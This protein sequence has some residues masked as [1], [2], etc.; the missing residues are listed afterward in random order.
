M[1]L[2]FIFSIGNKEIQLIDLATDATLKLSAKRKISEESEPNKEVLKKI[3]R[4]S[5]PVKRKSELDDSSHKL[6][7]PTPSLEHQV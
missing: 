4:K 3:K 6:V 1:L 2:L 5:L 7:M